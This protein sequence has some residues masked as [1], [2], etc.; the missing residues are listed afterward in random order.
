M[1]IGDLRHRVT[2]QTP[3]E[4]QDANGQPIKTFADT[5]IRYC[6]I[7]PLS[8]REYERAKAQHSE[9]SH[10]IT[11]RHFALTPKDKLKFGTRYFNVLSV[12]DTKEKGLEIVCLA[13]EIV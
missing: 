8:G 4:T 12:L 6:A 11:M 13:V 3:T 7:E 9:V 5:A 10:K 1:K 2:I